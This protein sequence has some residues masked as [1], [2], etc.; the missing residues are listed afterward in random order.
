MVAVVTRLTP[1]A[2]RQEELARIVGELAQKVRANEPH[3]LEYRLVRSR[4]EPGVYLLLER[5]ADDGALTDHVNAAHYAE[6]VPALMECL[7]GLPEI[8]IY[9]EVG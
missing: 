5:Y 8:A 9:D 2:G 6:V 7:D 3:C 4:H 1:G